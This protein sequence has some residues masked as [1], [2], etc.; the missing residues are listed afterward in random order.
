MRTAS[1]FV[2]VIIFL[3]V[4]LGGIFGYKFMQFGQMKEMLSQPQ[5][6]AIISVTK[7]T[8]E[9]WQP[10]IKAVGSVEAINGIEVANEVPG[11]I[12]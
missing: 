1:R 3:G 9:N 12:Q 2:I 8:T 7:A 6:P 11:V 10:A 4:V 5:P